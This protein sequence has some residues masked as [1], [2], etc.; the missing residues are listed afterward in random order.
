MKITTAALVLLLAL[1]AR[2]GAAGADELEQ[3]FITPPDA[4]R[5]WVYWYFMDGNLTREGMTA[6]LEAMRAAGIGGAIFLEVDIGIPRG[7]VEFMSA[8]WRVLFAHAAHEAERL[9]LQLALGTGPGWCGTGGPWVKPEQSMQHLVASATNVAGP[10]HFDAVLPR[11]VPRTPYFGEQTLTPELHR[12]WADFYRD[13]CVLAFPTPAG[14]VRLA[15]ADEK[16]LYFRAPFSSKPGVKPYL[17]APA[18]FPPLPADQCIATNRLLDLTARRAADG[19]LVWDVPPGDW[20]ILRFGRT[21]TGQTTRPAP[22][23]GLGFES[24]KFDRAALDAHFA[25]FIGQL[26]Q[27]VG[28]RSKPE[29]GLTMIHFDSWEMS[30]QNWSEHFRAD[31]RQRRGY[32]PLPFL[33]ALLGR[34]VAS[35]E[36]SERFLWDLRQTAQEL[37]ITNHAVRL[38]EL[39][40]EHNLTLSIE[41]Y[42]LNP[43]SDLEL[44]GAADVPQCEFWSQGYGFPTEFSCIEAASI[45]HTQGRS[46]VAAEA[47]TALPGEDWKRFPG[48]MK[49]QG[50]WALCCGINRFAFH[51]Y[52]HQPWLD[53]WPG[54][55][56]GPYGVHWERT[57][58]WWDM[59]GAYHTYLARCQALLRRGAPVAD[60]LYLAAEGAPHVFQAPASAL[61]KG[62]PDRRGYNF[63]GV[64]PGALLALAMVENGRINFP[65]GASY[66]VL[67]L[68]RVAAM[69]PALLG[70]IKQL[71][72]A[73]ATVVGAPPQRAPGLADFPRCDADVRQLARDIWGDA[74]R[75][76]VFPDTASAPAAPAAAH[77]LTTAQWIWHNEALPPPVG[78]RQFRREVTLPADRPVASATMLMTA[79]NAFELFVNGHAAGTGHNFHE[80]T[81]MDVIALLQPGTNTL[82]VTAEN[83]GDAPNPAGLIGVLSV[84]FDDGTKLSVPTD[85]RWSSALTTGGTWAA[86]RE[87]GPMGMAPWHLVSPPPKEPELY[88]DYAAT[89]ALLAQFGVMPDFESTGDLRYIHRREGATDI[90]FVGN[91]TAQPLA[92]EGRFRVTGKQPELWDPLTGER[93][94]LPSFSECD[95]RTTVPL[96]FAPAQSFFVIFRQ[97]VAAAAAAAVKNFPTL[98][99]LQELTGPWQVQFVPKVGRPFARTFQTLE[100]WTQR[101]DPDTKY[102]SGTATYR[103]TFSISHPPSA[104]EHL[105]LD[106][107]TVHI[108]A[109]VKLNGRDLGVVWCAPWRCA[110]PA[111][112]LR[113]SGN[114]LEI[115]V[116]N[117]WV[118]RLVGDAALPEAE[119]QTWTTRNPYKKDAPLLPSGLLGPVRLM[120]TEPAK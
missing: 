33:P 46:I 54:M 47:F 117:L 66:R 51:R 108:M 36:V 76:H 6:D 105:F 71:V 62:L 120:T 8:P 107:G 95:G 59:A 78:V 91:R 89:A 70:K 48:A 113:A 31:F 116:A 37:V 115:T 21:T 2:C 57:Q 10:A 45:A 60:I 84:K 28:P 61:L 24:D 35:P 98:Q 5:P 82:A 40:R 85:T 114:E 111:G 112:M 106:L 13:E 25:A 93:R 100:D 86:A 16:A 34:V 92:T 7:P 110:L 11:P 103:S 74:H 101:P 38:K 32:D 67:V 118:N 43:T 79:D 99:P 65:G 58:T 96:E 17:P 119:R 3:Q 81:E 18:V 75:G 73:G 69:T 20:T 94:A 80:V 15:D 30:S 12:L 56:M 72:A 88:P 22:R 104:L 102:F 50:D 26:L 19:R 29:A 4:A 77:P 55:T 49:L 52:Q 39:G 44:G 53:R 97:P 63:D 1:A 83:G 64:A 14:A 42:D 87:L 27:D 90:Y 9:G 41:P 68:P 23:P 109:Q